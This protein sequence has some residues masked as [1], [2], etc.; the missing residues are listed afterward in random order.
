VKKLFLP[1]ALV[2][3][4]Q[5]YEAAAVMPLE[6]KSEDVYQAG[7]CRALVEGAVS[8]GT[9]QIPIQAAGTVRLHAGNLIGGGDNLHS[10]TLGEEAARVDL[11]EI[12]GVQSGVKAEAVRDGSLATKVEDCA[13]FLTEIVE[14]YQ[15]FSCGYGTKRQR[16]LDTFLEVTRE[17]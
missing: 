3:C 12:L 1:L 17:K 15:G 14:N 10:V 7:Y 4:L 9:E 11:I 6:I 16:S 8:A 13:T 2:L 5:P